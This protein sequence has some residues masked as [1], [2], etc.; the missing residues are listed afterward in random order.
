ML[1]AGN[2]LSCILFLLLGFGL[3]FV[4]RW[5][6]LINLGLSFLLALSLPP[7]WS[8]GMIIG[9]WISCA[10]FTFNPEQEQHQFEIAVI[11]W[12]KAF[13][14]A[15]WTFTGF[16]LTLIFLWKLKI[17]GNLELLPREI[18]AWSFLFLVEICLYRIISL[19]APRFYRIPLG[20]GIAVFHFLMLFYWIFPWGIWLS[21]LV[22]LSLLIVN[23]LLLVAVDIQFNAQDPI[24][25]RK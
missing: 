21:G 7:A 15:L 2:I 18:M 6:P 13:L 22:L 12:R 14:A 5:S 16:L 10:F 3:Q 9:S 23:P 4:I 24:F 8:M 1:T 17:S 19:L 20:Y 25:R 11:T